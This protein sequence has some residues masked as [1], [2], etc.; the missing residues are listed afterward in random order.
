MPNIE[1]IKDKIVVKG[2]NYSNLP[3]KDIPKEVLDADEYWDV[4]FAWTHVTI[5]GDGKPILDCLWP[6]KIKKQRVFKNCNLSG[7]VIPPDS[8]FPKG[9]E[10]NTYVQIYEEPKEEWVDNKDGTE[11]KEIVSVQRFYGKT[12]C[13]TLELELEKT[14]RVLETRKTLDGV[15]RIKEIVVGK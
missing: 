5:G 12:S 2:G 15:T 8:V 9:Y 6:K 10:G 14:P 3:A 11:H 7:R 4:N 1:I 13:K